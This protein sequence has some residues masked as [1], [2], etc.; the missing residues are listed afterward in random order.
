VNILKSILSSDFFIISAAKLKWYSQESQE[1]EVGSKSELLVILVS[2][3]GNLDP[4]ITQ[5]VWGKKE[6]G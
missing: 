1:L 2:P 3:L 5:T 6:A 4:E